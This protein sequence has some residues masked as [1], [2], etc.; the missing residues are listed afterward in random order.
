MELIRE[1]SNVSSRREED[2]IIENPDDRKLVTNLTDTRLGFKLLRKTR[3]KLNRIAT[4]ET[5]IKDV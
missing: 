2:R 3:L 1:K 4:T 5:D